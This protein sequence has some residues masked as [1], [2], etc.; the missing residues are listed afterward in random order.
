MEQLSEEERRIRYKKVAKADLINYLIES[1][2][3][4]DEA[5]KFRFK[6]IPNSDPVNTERPHIT[7]HKCPICCGTGVVPIG[8]Y[9][10]Y[11]SSLSST[12]AGTTEPCRSCTGTGIVWG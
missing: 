7:P 8:Y 5:E 12:T 2:I 4:L 11:R 6:L 9:S 1:Q 3:K 10:G